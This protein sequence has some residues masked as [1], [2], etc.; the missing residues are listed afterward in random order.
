M[1]DT[2]TFIILIIAVAVVAAAAGAGAAVF[3]SRR[4]IKQLT[5]NQKNE[6]SSTECFTEMT[7]TVPSSEGSTLILFDEQEELKIFIYDEDDPSKKYEISSSETIIGRNAHM[8]HIAIT[9]DANISQKHCKIF[10]RD[11]VV[12]ISDMGSLNHTYVNGKPVGGE[13]ALES[14]NIIGIGKKKLRVEIFR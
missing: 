9:D 2:N 6:D 5:D 4:K 3:L 14:G 1:N 7:S 13:K 8:S 10:V 11:G 12:Y